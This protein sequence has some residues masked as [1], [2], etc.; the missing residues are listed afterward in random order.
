MLPAAAPNLVGCL[1]QQ[2][3]EILA[4]AHWTCRDDRSLQFPAEI[5]AIVHKATVIMH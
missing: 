2:Q 3:D 4:Q 1:V 5:E